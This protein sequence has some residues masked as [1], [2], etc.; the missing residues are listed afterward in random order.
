M[1]VKHDFVSAVADGADATLVRPSNWNA[2]HT[3]DNSTIT[4]DMLAGSI[5]ASKL[6]G[7][8]IA[9]VGTITT[10]TWNGTDVAVGAGGTGASGAQAA[11]SN[12][13]AV[14]IL[15]KGSA[16]TAPAD[17]ELNTLATI[18]IPAGAMGANGHIIVETAWTFTNNANVKTISVYFNG[19]GGTDYLALAGASI[20]TAKAF[21]YIT[22]Q[23]DA[24]AQTGSSL[25]F[26]GTT[27]VQNDANTVTSTVDTTAAVNIAIAA[28]KATGTDTITL[29]WYRVYLLANGT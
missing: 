14:Y 23:N 20:G 28:Q 21:T 9:T 29:V 8:D 13:A 1:A 16:V 27:Q 25:E 24:A 19:T 3:I 12:L 17:T 6:V 11:C 4:N 7:T 5:A 2:A 22:N 26:R 10:G 15:G 18:T